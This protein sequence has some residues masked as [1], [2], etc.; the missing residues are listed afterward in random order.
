VPDFV[1][2]VATA[3]GEIVERTYSADDEGALRHDLENQ[4]LLVLNL[5]RTNSLVDQVARTFRLRGSISQ[6]D[7]LA[8][9]KEFVALI[10]AGLPILSSLE[11]LTERRKNPAFRRALVDIRERVKSGEALSDAFMA[12]GSLFP[13]LYSASLASGERSGELGTVIARFVEYSARVLA[14]QRKV[15]S[16]LIYPAILL[17]L[18]TGLIAL[19]M[20]VIIPKFN[21]FL[22]DFGQDLPLLTKLVVGLAMACRS[23]WHVILLVLVGGV[24]TLVLWT[25]TPAGRTW[26][27]ALKLRV[28]LLGR[29][30]GDY[31]QSRFT[32]TLATLQAGGIPL[33]TSIELSGG[34]VGNVVY[35]R[36]LAEVGNRVREGSSLW[37]ALDRTGLMADITIQMVKVGESTGALVE[38]LNH[39]SDFTDEE[40]DTRL[41]RLVTLIEPLMLVF[42]AVIIATMLLSIYLPLIRVYGA[43]V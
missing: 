36:S 26:F 25:R 42:M 27:D 10:R 5:R 19:M 9:N 21:E 16:A 35:E 28:P 17:T 4:D 11:I 30:I 13:R 39:A 29:V 43:A 41:S 31:A 37:E 33:V 18:S 40:I 6:R 32:R 23:Y 34:A 38:M 1:C 2:R 22:K 20:F 15:V 24:A 3:T 8:F 12:H 7:F 14:I